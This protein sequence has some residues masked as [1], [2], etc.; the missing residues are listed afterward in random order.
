MRNRS[1]TVT[2]IIVVLIV[3]GLLNMMRMNPKAFLIPLIVFGVIFLL[4]KYPPDTW[5]RSSSTKSS[6]ERNRRNVQKAKFRVIK[7]SKGIQD[8]DE[9][10]DDVPKYH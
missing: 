3:L 10:Q 5:R 1:N 9:K 4:W 6:T 7:G 8:D 2:T